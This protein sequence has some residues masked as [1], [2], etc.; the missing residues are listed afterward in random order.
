MTW[1]ITIAG[2][3]GEAEYGSEEH[4]A[5]EE[6]LETTAREMVEDLIAEG[7]TVMAASFNGNTRTAN[8]L[9]APEEAKA[10]A[11]GEPAKEGAQA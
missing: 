4:K 8:L 10:G 11:E 3:Q 9:P 6:S 7:H 2:H 1:N 5:Q